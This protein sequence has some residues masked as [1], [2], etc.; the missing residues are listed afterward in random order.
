LTNLNDVD[1][2]PPVGEEA[3]AMVKLAS[4]EWSEEALKDWVAKHSVM[5][6]NFSGTIQAPH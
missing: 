1:F 6:A 2:S 4:G 3:D 5:R